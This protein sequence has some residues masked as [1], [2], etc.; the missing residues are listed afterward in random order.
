MINISHMERKGSFDTA[1]Y[2]EQFKAIR[3]IIRVYALNA[4]LP[5]DYPIK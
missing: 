4:Q 2:A 5:K 1:P 3:A